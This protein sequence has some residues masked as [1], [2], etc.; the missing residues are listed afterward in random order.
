M[1]TTMNE[2]EAQE[3]A[4]DPEIE[5]DK[6]DH[7]DHDK[8]EQA[9]ALDDDDQDEAEASKPAPSSASRPSLRR[10]RKSTQAYTVTEFRER[11]TE[12]SV[13]IL[14]PGRGTPLGDLD[15]TRR[16]MEE[17]TPTEQDMVHQFLF[18]RKYRAKPQKKDVLPNILQV[19]SPCHVIWRCRNVKSTAC[20]S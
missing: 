6:K 18:Q 8:N 15:A 7:S 5:T 12:A 4:D 3:L 1:D 16:A 11:S 10:E 9:V 19:S 17:A 2:S 14:P 13:E 20:C